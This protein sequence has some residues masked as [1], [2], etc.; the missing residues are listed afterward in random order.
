MVILGKNNSGLENV[1]LLLLVLSM[2]AL[3]FFVQL[4][5]SIIGGG[6][7]IA[8]KHPELTE[9]MVLLGG[10]LA[11]AVVLRRIKKLLKIWTISIKEL[12]P[13]VS[14]EFKWY[15]FSELIICLSFGLF[16]LSTVETFVL[17]N[18]GLSS[19]SILLTL[20]NF[21][22][23]NIVLLYISTVLLAPITEEL[24]FRGII[25]RRLGIK[26]NTQKAIIVSSFV[27][28]I[29]H[30]DINFFTLFFLGIILSI[31]YY[32]TK[33]LIV[34]MV[35]HACYNFIIVS[36]WTLSNVVDLDLQ[37]VNVSATVMMSLSA[38]R[39]IFYL[40]KNWPQKNWRLPS[41]DGSRELSRLDG[42]MASS[43]MPKG[44]QHKIN[45]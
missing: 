41:F 34:P 32:Q 44:D 17:N 39:G 5:V 42:E 22:V 20:K 33:T 31:L 3:I 25:L 9:S 14:K 18:L 21:S 35:F 7:A 45:I 27:F 1:S 37:V 29:L 19:H 23:L 4:L 28:S 40:I 12:V 24:F 15:R 2:V 16:G 10:C 30:F 11:Y 43:I 6:I 13:S 8:L 26:H 36:I 38:I